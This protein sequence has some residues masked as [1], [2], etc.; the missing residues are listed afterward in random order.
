[1][2][3]LPRSGNSFTGQFGLSLNV[4]FCGTCVCELIEKY[5]L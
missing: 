3:R 4:S 5:Q 2:I 1:M